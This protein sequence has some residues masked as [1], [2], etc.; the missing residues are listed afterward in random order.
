MNQ[1][2]VAVAAGLTAAAISQF[3]TGV[4]RPA[5]ETVDRLALALGFPTQTFLDQLASA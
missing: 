4:S 3:E 2:D 1:V 5:I